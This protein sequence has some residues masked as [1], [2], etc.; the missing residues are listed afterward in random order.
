M[1]RTTARDRAELIHFDA[2]D[3]IELSGL[4]YEPER[5]VRRAAIFLHGTGGASIF[6]SRRTNLLAHEF[7]SRGMA[8][9]PFNNRGAHLI[10]ELR[11]VMWRRQ[12]CLRS[13]K[14][15]QTGLSAPL[16]G[17]AHERI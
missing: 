17:M 7:T 14:T 8:W 10:R 3:G 16:G 4:L 2:T 1:G 9:F 5:R 15:A 6:D 12:S 11:G 13:G